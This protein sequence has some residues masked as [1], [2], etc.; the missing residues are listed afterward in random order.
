MSQLA[1]SVTKRLSDAEHV[2][3]MNR[4][5]FQL[6][7][8]DRAQETVM[9]KVFFEQTKILVADTVSSVYLTTTEGYLKGYG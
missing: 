8:L 2:T 9:Y 5:Y 3:S 7:V 4:A 1:N 6:G